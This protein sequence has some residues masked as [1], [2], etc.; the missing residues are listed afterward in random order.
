M[1]DWPHNTCIYLFF[2]LNKLNDYC[3]V[4]NINNKLINKAQIFGN[5]LFEKK[6]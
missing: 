6:I 1:I 3:K 2:S 4:K 5:L